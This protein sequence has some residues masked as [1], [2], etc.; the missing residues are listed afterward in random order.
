[1]YD[2][3]DELDLL[4][5]D[6]DGVIE[7]CLLDEES[8]EKGSKPPDKSGCCVAFFLIG[9]SLVGLAGALVAII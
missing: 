7:M 1:M 9:S 3:D 5:D 4:D 6:G 8:S 2:F